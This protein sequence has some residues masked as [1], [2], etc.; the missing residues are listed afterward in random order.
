MAP[1]AATLRGHRG[2]GEIPYSA[3]PMANPEM[4]SA[5]S[6]PR[7]S[8][9]VPVFNGQNTIADALTSALSQ[10]FQQAEVIVTNDGSTDQTASILAG[11]GSA[12]RVIDQSHRGVS[13]ARNSA[14]H[15]SRGEYLAFLDADDVWLAGKLTQTVAALKENPSAVLVFSDYIRILDSGL[16]GESSHIG[17]TPSMDDLLSRGWSILPS[18]VVMRKSV[19]E[20][21]GG[22]SEKLPRL[23]DPY[24]WLLARELGEFAYAAEP[25]VRYRETS[26]AQLASKYESGRL[27][28]F[29]LL[30]ERY[31]SRAAP[32]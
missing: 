15:A 19:Y 4:A 17:G 32:L 7:V 25:L 28:L 1:F 18:T 20:R 9:I 11:F 27:P 14:A 6:S 26:I 13:A 31:G 21:C 5:S 23:E 3:R 10:D 29:R 22:C 8:V 30:N 24:L 2:A 12:I 16:Q